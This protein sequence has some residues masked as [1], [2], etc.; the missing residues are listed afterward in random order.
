MEKT[1]LAK[2]LA[3]T[4]TQMVEIDKVREEAND[5]DLQR[6]LHR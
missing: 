1:T 3:P 4:Q 2:L 5:W 6:V